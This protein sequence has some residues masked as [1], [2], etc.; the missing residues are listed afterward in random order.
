[1]TEQAAER[2][3]E[4][5]MMDR[6]QQTLMEFGHGHAFV[7]QQ[8]RFDVDGDEFVVDILLF[9]TSQ[10]RFLCTN[11]RLSTARSRARRR[12]PISSGARRKN[13]KILT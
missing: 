5:A 11:G 13:K 9:N 1:M 12:W 7:G 3:L 6:L 10:L 2:D 4:Q 8:V